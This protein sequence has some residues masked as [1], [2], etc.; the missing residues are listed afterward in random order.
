M[1]HTPDETATPAA[2]T[3]VPHWI[4]TV[5][6]EAAAALPIQ[7]VT[8]AHFF[9]MFNV[10]RANELDMLLNTAIACNCHLP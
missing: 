5:L 10:Q 2:W 7:I 1:T 9:P 4:G 3:H 6:P 8:D